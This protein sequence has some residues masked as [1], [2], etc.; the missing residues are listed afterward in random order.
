ME[1]EHN[2][3]AVTVGAGADMAGG[4]GGGGKGWMN[5]RLHNGDIH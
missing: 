5:Q 1:R 2:S 3:I 4:W